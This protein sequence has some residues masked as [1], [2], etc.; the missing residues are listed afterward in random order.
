MVGACLAVHWE[1]WQTW[2]ADAWVM[3]VL[4]FGYQVP[5]RSLP[6]LSHVPLPLPSYSPFSI[7]GLALTAAVSDL[8]AKEAIE[9]AP[10]SPGFYSRL[11]VTP[12][13]TGGWR[14]V[15]DLSC[16]NGFVDVSHFHME[17]TQT[18]LQSLREGDWLVSLDLQ[19]A[20]LQVPVTSGFA[21]GSRFTSSA[22]SV[23]ASQWLLYP[24]HCPCLRD[25]ASSWLPDPPV[26]R[27]LAGPGF[28]LPGERS[29]EGFFS[30]ALP[31]SWD[32]SQSPQELFDSHADSGLSRDYDPDYSFDGFP[33]PQADPEVVSSSSGLSVNPVS[34]GVRLET[35][36]GDHVFDVSSGSRLQ[37]PDAYASDSSQCG[38][39]SP[40]RRL[41][42]GVGFRLPSG[43]SV[44]V[45]R[46][47]SSCWHASRRVSPRPVF[48]HRR[49]GH[50]LGASRRCP[51]R[52]LLGFPSI[53][54]SFW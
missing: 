38:W 1:T 14:P 42:G 49:V 32:P 5:F 18:V 41:P 15:I 34:S 54:E 27:R 33:D 6:P 46:L 28:H 35:T 9:L 10:P 12:K 17:T 4:Q 21:W 47:S 3:Q 52:R 8:L 40:A 44:V 11:F 20:Y 39:S 37:A 50:R 22:L 25:H 53:T 23:F 31:A 51:P 43:S 7:R 26:S 29:G 24:C 48:V 13:V 16:L 2:G 36:V 45:R 19:D 30:L